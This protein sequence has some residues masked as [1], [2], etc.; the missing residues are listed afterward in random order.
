VVHVT[1]APSIALPAFAEL[2]VFTA[3]VLNTVSVTTIPVPVQTVAGTTLAVE[4]VDK[5]QLHFFVTALPTEIE[6]LDA[7]EFPPW[8][9]SG[10]SFW[11][12]PPGNA[13]A[14]GESPVCRYFTTPDAG[15]NTHFYSAFP[16]ECDAIPALFPG[17][18]TSETTDAFGV[19]EPDTATGTC[20]AGTS[21]L[22][23]V[24][25]GGPNVN[26][27]Y[28]TST[29]T[30]DLM[31]RDIAHRWIPEGYGPLGVGMCVPQ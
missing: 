22:Y 3:N 5:D 24:Y 21:P 2:L 18:W 20:P 10:R 26:H 19:L 15:F 17:I 25:N 12:Y 14:D 27:R 29:D 13:I 28:V 23:R 7:G 11:V 16:Q 31:V 4:Y 1:Y 30:R 9:R 6:A 8:I